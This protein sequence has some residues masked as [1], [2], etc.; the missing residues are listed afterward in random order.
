MSPG[1]A[2]ASD[3]RLARLLQIGVVLEEMVEAGAYHHVRRR[4]VELDE[5]VAALLEEAA[6]ESAR[7]RER[8]EALITELDADS[9][10]YEEIQTLVEAQYAP[11]TSSTT[12]CTTSCVTRRRRTSSTTISWVRW[13]RP[14]T[15]RVVRWPTETNFSLDRDRLVATLREIRAEE[16]D[17]VE[18]VTNMMERRA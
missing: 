2:V 3:R 15:T 13:V 18:T 9:V 1:Q 6:T 10:A 7:H 8:L 17:G 4:E 5:P 14:T 11:P 12:Y 16:A